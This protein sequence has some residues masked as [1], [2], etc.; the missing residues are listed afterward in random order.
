[1]S[2][3]LSDICHHIVNVFESDGTS[4]DYGE[5]LNKFEH[6][7]NNEKLVNENKDD[8]SRIYN[9][10]ISDKKLIEFVVTKLYSKLNEGFYNPFVSDEDQTDI[11]EDDYINIEP[12]NDIKDENGNE[13]DKVYIDNNCVGGKIY[14]KDGKMFSGVNIEK[15]GVVEI[16]PVIPIDKTALCSRSVR[17]IAFEISPNDEWG[18]PMGYANMYRTTEQTG[19]SGNIDYEYPEMSDVMRFVAIDD[20]KP[21]DE[22][23]LRVEEDP[24]RLR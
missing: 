6:F 24:M 2:S 22:L 8:L 10:C 3:I 12:S 11:F 16:C 21:N 9:R 20:I 4:L 23:V 17:D 5:V 15:G 18:V 1:M 14:Y 13:I 7:T 19:T